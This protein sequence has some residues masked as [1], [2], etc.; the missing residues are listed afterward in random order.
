MQ[1]ES[2]AGMCQVCCQNFGL[3]K[4]RNFCK[5]CSVAI[6]KD[7]S[8]NDLL[9]YIPDKGKNNSNSDNNSA[10]PQ[11]AIIKIVGVRI[12]FW[13]SNFSLKYYLS[14]QRVAIIVNVTIFLPVYHLGLFGLFL[15]NYFD[16]TFVWL[17]FEHLMIASQMLLVT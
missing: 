10:E 16:T 17:V 5:V 3:L 13:C 7:C 14:F 12:S 15:F 4:K 1:Q 6:C 8:T 2:N 11:L 9:V